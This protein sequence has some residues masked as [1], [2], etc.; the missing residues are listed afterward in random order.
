[1][2]ITFE[3][4]EGCGKSTH[5]ERL[6]K[7]L[8]EKGNKVVLTREPGGTELGKTIREKLLDNDYVLESLTEVFLFAA[9][10]VEH[11]EKVIK[12]ALAK[13]QIVISDR[14]TDSTLAY[15][16][17]GR[18][19]PEDLIRYI[20][21]ISS[22]NLVPDV[23][24]LLD[25]P[26]EDGLERAKTKHTEPDRFETEI[27]AFHERVRA[28]YLEI[29][30]ENNDRI[31]LINSAIEMRKVFEEIKKVIDEVLTKK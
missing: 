29:Y 18:G 15:Q 27:I 17:G 1:M 13:G 28:K 16:L 22:K 2:F 19:L 26:V 8:E 12:P 6:K 30:Q 4:C 31:Y 10:R 11:V 9:D 5:A 25:I 24:F 21:W 20:N 3:G 7:Y 23:T 14:F